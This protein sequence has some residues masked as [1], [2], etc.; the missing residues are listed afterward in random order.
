MAEFKIFRA[1]RRVH[2][3][4]A[5]LDFRRADFGL[6]RDLLGRVPWDTPGGKRGPRKKADIQDYLLCAHLMHP[7]KEEVRQ[8]C[9]LN[10]WTSSSLI[11][12]SRKRKSIEG[13]RNG[14]WSWRNI[15]RFFK[16][17]FVQNIS[18]YL[19]LYHQHHPKNRNSDSY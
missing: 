18:S 2:S 11:N 3:K 15:W 8:K 9:H 19:H 5:I 17:I 10:G 13:G 1:A 4:L 14:R 7:N 16:Q 12:S 6:Y